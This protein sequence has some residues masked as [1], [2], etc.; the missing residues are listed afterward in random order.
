MLNAIIAILCGLILLSGAVKAFRGIAKALRPIEGILGLIA[1]V[2]GI[3]GILGGLSL[4]A[5][6]LILAGLILAVSLIPSLS[7]AAKALAPFRVVIGLVAL[8][9]GIIG[10][11]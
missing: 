3:I 10:L 7:G 9:V 6:T 1:L 8:I 5:I 4:M 11:L 2:L